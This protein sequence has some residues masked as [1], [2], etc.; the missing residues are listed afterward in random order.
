MT[1]RHVHLTGAISTAKAT[2]QS[3][4]DNTTMYIKS[5]L[6]TLVAAIALVA[7]DP[8]AQLQIGVK[9]KPESCL[10]KTRKG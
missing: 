5:I 7:A 6:I 4:L 2:L 3:Q 1:H 8:K 9:H 10:V